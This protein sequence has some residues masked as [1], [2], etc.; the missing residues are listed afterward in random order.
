M[1]ESNA[2]NIYTDGSAYSHPRMGGIGIRFIKVDELGNETRNDL[3]LRGY[4]GATNIQM[5]LQAVIM[6]LK[7]AREEQLVTESKNIYIFTD[8]Q[9][10]S[11]NYINAM[12]MWP[13]MK[14]MGKYNQPIEHAKLWKEFNKEVRK[15]GGRVHIKWVKGHKNDEDNRAVDK[16]AKRSAKDAYNKPLIIVSVRRKLT[17]KKINIGCVGLE[18]QRITIRIF[19]CQ[20]LPEQKLWKYSYEVVS[21]NSIYFGLSDKIVS[22]LLLKDGHT[23]YVKFNNEQ[24]N[25]RIVK[26]YNEVEKGKSDHAQHAA[27]AD[28]R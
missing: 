20:E 26:L 17:Q 8:C 9:Y 28:P 15:I 23:Y 24:N 4:K 6:A 12:F 7:T 10:V 5:E 3:E 27:A 13:K 25:P 21:K 11:S 14:W 1:I 16:L 18:G 2:L 22:E 19:T